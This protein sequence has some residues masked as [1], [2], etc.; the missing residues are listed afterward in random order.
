MA[1][2]TQK[3]KM[4]KTLGKFIGVIPFVMLGVTL[5][6][7]ICSN[8]DFY[9]DIFIYLPDVL[10]YSILTNIVFLYHFS[11]NKYCNVTRS[12]VWGLLVMNLVSIA[13]KNT[14]YYSSLYDIYIVSAVLISM[15]IFKIKRW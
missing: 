14:E 9:S 5:L 3:N 12:A 6:C 7:A 4:Q 10:G 8:F 11:F 15:L 2:K 1:S 13:T